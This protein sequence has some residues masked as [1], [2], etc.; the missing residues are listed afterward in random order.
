MQLKPE[1]ASTSV[2]QQADNEDGDEPTCNIHREDKDHEDSKNKSDDLQNKTH[3]FASGEEQGEY[4]KEG[5]ILFPGKR[6]I[7]KFIEMNAPAN[8]SPEVSHFFVMPNCTNAFFFFGYNLPLYISH[9]MS[10]FSSLRNVCSS[11]SLYLGHNEIHR[12]N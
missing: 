10:S 1:F 12:G 3:M 7:H 9:V 6:K 5:G 2:P 11:F 4:K 8:R